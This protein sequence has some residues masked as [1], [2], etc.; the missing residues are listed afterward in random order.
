MYGVCVQFARSSHGPLRSVAGTP[1]NMSK[2][3]LLHMAPNKARIWPC[4]AC[5]FQDRSTAVRVGFS[6]I[7]GRASNSCFACCPLHP[8]TDAL[9]PEART[10]ITGGLL[11][12]LGAVLLTHI[13]SQVPTHPSPIRHPQPPILHLPPPPSAYPRPSTT[14]LPPRILT[15]HR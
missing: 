8:H 10:L 14:L 3:F 5:L 1:W 4:L 11:L 7:L 15:Y 9:K 2:T 13:A 6:P 12:M